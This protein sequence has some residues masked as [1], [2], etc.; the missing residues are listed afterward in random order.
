MHVCLKQLN[1]IKSL[2]CHSQ[3]SKQH[4]LAITK[5]NKTKFL[6]HLWS[7][8]SFCKANFTHT[9]SSYNTLWRDNSRQRTELVNFELRAQLQGN[10]YHQEQNVHLHISERES[11]KKTLIRRKAEWKRTEGSSLSLEERIWTNV[12]KKTIVRKDI[13]FMNFGKVKW[14]QGL[15]FSKCLFAL[16]TSSTVLNALNRGF[17]PVRS[18]MS[19]CKVETFIVYVFEVRKPRQRCSIMF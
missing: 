3:P 16:G 14:R 11:R 1:M 5:Y 15:T 10:I 9:H 4:F 2:S 18:L 8:C 19:P 12:E 13:Y 6:V 17:H 7:L